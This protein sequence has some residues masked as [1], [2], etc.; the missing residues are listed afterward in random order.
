V[1]VL[2]VDLDRQRHLAVDVAVAVAVLLE[3]AVDAVHADVGVDGRH[4]HR[5]VELVRVVVGHAIGA[6]SAS[7]RLPL[8]SRLKTAR[9]FQ[10]W[11]W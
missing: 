1:A 9:K 2:A 6:P 4:V 7:S 5:L 8:R 3:V 11:P 10:P